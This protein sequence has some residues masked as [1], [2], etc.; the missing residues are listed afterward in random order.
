MLHSVPIISFLT[1]FTISSSDI[2][3]VNTHMYCWFLIAWKD[4]NIYKLQGFQVRRIYGRPRLGYA[5]YYY[6]SSTLDINLL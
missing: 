1:N 2:F 5:R 4:F 3:Q 6:Y